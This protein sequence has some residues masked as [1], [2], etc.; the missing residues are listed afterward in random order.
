MNLVPVTLRAAN[1]YIEEHH[2]HHGKVQGHKFSIGAERGGELIGVV[3]V[4]RPVA[5]MLDDGKTAEVTRLCVQEGFRNACSKLY[6]A[7]W[8]AARAMGYLRLVTYILASETGITLKA[9]GWTRSEQRSEGG[10]WSRPSRPRDDKHPLE[11]KVRWEV[12]G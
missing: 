5:R 11:P 8:R 6:A 12:T 10:S 4:G 2:R 7:A 9:A 3:V 1:A